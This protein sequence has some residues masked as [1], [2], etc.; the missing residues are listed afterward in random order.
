MENKIKDQIFKMLLGVLVGFSINSYAHSYQSDEKEKEKIDV[1][2]RLKEQE[3]FL[4]TVN[5]ERSKSDWKGD[6]IAVVSWWDVKGEEQSQAVTSGNNWSAE[7]ES[8]GLNYSILCNQKHLGFSFQIIF[9]V[10]DNILEVNIPSSGITEVGE[11]RLKSIRLLPRFGAAQEDNEGYLV[12]SKDVGVLCHFKDKYPTEKEIPVYGFEHCNMPLFGIVRGKSAMAGIIKCGQ[13]DAQLYVSTNWGTE[14]QYAIDPVF[15]LRSFP[16][17]KRLTDNLIVLYNFLPVAEASWL[18]IAKCY[19]QYNSVFRE[20]KPLRERVTSSPELAYSSKAL[21]VR[22]RLGVKPVPTPILEQTTENEPPV[23]IFLPFGKVCDIFKEFHRQ[24]ID[25]VEF[26]LVGWNK[27]GHDGRF[28]QLFPVEPVLGG[29]SELR[30][31]ITYGQSLGY[32]VVAHDAYTGGFSISEDWDEEFIRKKSD[33]QLLKGGKLA[34][35]QCYKICLSRSYDLFAKRDMPRIRELGFKGVHYS[36]VLSIVGPTP[37]YDINHP[38]T[39]REDAEARNKILALSKN[40]F[41]GIQSEGPLDFTA[42]VLDRVLYISIHSKNSP[43][44]ELPYVD[45]MVPL[46]PAVYHGTLLYNIWNDCVNSSP[47]EIEYLKNIEYGGMPVAYFYGHFWLDPDKNWLGERDLRY[48]DK[49]ALQKAV[50]GLYHVYDDLQKLNHLQM[51]FIEGHNKLSDGV[52][53]TV[54]SNGE[55]VVVNYN[56]TLF[57]KGTGEEVPANGFSLLK[58]DK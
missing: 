24:G 10:H 20:I 47:G 39:R 12:L 9:I 43:L 51:E 53:E 33:G 35:G 25:K 50:K 1:N 32:Q 22:L 23:R 44:M 56:D 6:I 31:T 29:E 30:K 8:T 34:G 7:L 16:E 48:D 13:F 38:L 2:I 45:T 15:T 42:P 41:G 57:R 36:D 21:E 37:C 5:C 46:Y 3:D 17:E 58:P 27:S 54:Y 11:A 49:P 18:G 40:I 55:R 4:L 28:P 52:F 14:H 26:C 19:R